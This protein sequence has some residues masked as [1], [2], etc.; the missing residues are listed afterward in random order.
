M[1]TYVGVGEGVLSSSLRKVVAKS[2]LILLSERK[3]TDGVIPW[4]NHR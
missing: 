4:Y 2:R 1:K 3:I